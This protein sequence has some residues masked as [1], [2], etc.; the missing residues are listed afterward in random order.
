MSELLKNKFVD[1]EPE[2]ER[3]LW[4]GIDK[5]LRVKKKTDF[6]SIWKKMAVAASVLIVL[7]SV[8]VGILVPENQKNKP[9]LVVNNNAF[10]NSSIDR[11]EAVASD[12]EPAS[13][14]SVTKSEKPLVV[15]VNPTTRPAIQSGSPQKEA[16]YVAPVV[17]TNENNGA[18]LVVTKAEQPKVNSSPI[19]ISPETPISEPSNPAN[20]EPEVIE[21]EWVIYEVPLKKKKEEVAPA[22]QRQ[23][24]N[25]SKTLNMNALNL[26][27]VATFTTNQVSKVMNTPFMVKQEYENGHKNVTYEVDLKNIKIIQ[28]KHK[29]IEREY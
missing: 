26:E 20:D 12:I 10:L 8:L 7:G 15:R 9:S 11:A 13:V 3:D 14:S 16:T 19:P 5:K 21:T 17:E 28:R 24:S 27:D 2:P 4:A 29:P 25:P 6:F 1:F 23:L 18:N 22:K